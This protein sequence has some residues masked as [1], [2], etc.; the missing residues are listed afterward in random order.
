MSTA[1]SKISTPSKDSSHADVDDGADAASKQ[2]ANP[3]ASAA[4]VSE[5]CDD[6]QVTTDQSADIAVIDEDVSSASIIDSE[7]SPVLEASQAASSVL[8]AADDVPA[9]ELN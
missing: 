7:I 9:D 2:E 8:A 6:V 4:G 3:V 5:V 1:D